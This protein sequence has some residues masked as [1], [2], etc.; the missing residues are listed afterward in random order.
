ML[1]T[2]KLLS[3]VASLGMMFVLIGGALVTKTGSG[4]GCGESWPLCEGQLFPSE[5]T[6]E[7]IIEL[8]H[9]LISGIMGFVVLTLSIL[10]WI[11]VGHIREVKFLSFMS[12]FFLILQALIGAAAVMWNQSDFI[13]A[14]HFGISLISFTA[15]F[16]LML[17]IFEVDTKFDAKSL[18][19]EKKH[20]T[21][22]YAITIYTV[23]VVYTGALVRHVE[24]SMVCSG[25]PF[26]SNN[27][28]L[29][30][31]DYGFDQWVQM[32]HRLA[33]GLL[34]IW[35]VILTIKM[36]KRYGEHRVMNWG[37]I[38]TV[39]L[40]AL[41]AFFGAM[42]IFTMLNLWIALMHAFVISCYFAMLSYFVLLS[43]RSARH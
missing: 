28:P 34:F 2:L 41:Q 39:L 37:W 40:I 9:R 32:G 42:I 5:V 27:S 30:L 16:L 15:V 3:V 43:S 20:R 21:E 26:C 24:A 35:T 11:V 10:S 18:T 4:L 22:I 6:P 8:S 36:I 19:I 12:S 25:W 31:S 23:I 29:A 17:L 7:L 13:M 38:T 33:A 1:K 14:T